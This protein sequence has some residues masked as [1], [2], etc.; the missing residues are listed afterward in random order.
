MRFLRPDWAKAKRNS[1][2]PTT[3]G[4]EETK[5]MALRWRRGHR[6]PDASMSRRL[7]V[8]EP[9]PRTP[10]AL[11]YFIVLTALCLASSSG[12]AEDYKYP[13]RDPYI[14]TVTAAILTG[15]GL[16]PK[17]K[18]AGCSCAGPPD[19]NHMPALEGR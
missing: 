10:R 11:L 4:P 6:V 15:D 9:Y 8:H 17:P 16:T 18:H 13:F 12:E 5:V 3:G 2:G 1:L 19:R 14:A 7:Q